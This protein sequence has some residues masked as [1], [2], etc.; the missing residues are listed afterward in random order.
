MLVAAC[1][2]LIFLKTTN[3]ISVQFLALH[4]KACAGL[5]DFAPKYVYTNFNVF[6]YHT[7]DSIA[8]EGKTIEKPFEKHKQCPIKFAGK[9]QFAKYK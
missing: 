6:L 7:E 3:P 4:R 1:L 2:L 9:I 8:K 5:F